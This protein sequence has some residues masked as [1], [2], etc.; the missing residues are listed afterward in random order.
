MI[1]KSEGLTKVAESSKKGKRIKGGN[2]GIG[3]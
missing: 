3:T 1:P 2:H